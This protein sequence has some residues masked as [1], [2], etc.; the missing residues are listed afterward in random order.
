MLHCWVS[1]WQ[2]LKQGFAFIFKGQRSMNN[3][4][5]AEYHTDI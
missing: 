3:E 5:E 1:G 4:G 2:H